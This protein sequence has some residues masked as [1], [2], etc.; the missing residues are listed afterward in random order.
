VSENGS[1]P[2]AGFRYGVVFLLILIVVV[3]L[4]VAPA[5]DWAFAAVF[6]LEGAALV[7]VV[8]TSRSRPDVRRARTALSAAAAA[9]WVL[10]VALGAIPAVLL[11]AA[12]GLITILI[13]LTLV[14]GLLRLVRAR[15]VTLQVVAGAL[16]IYLLLG[17]T[18]AW[19]IGLATHL[20]SAPYFASGT[21]GTQS[22]RVYFSFSVLTTTGFGDLTAGNA[23]GRALAVLEMLIG[24][25]YLVTVI[26]VLVGNFG[27]R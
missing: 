27:R 20:S 4:I 24:Q 18:F 23:P 5:N 1:A 16:A 19:V 9:A 15:G 17:L 10:G 7:V 6:A 25:L 3:V 22:T 21:D 2:A 11:Q 8:A 12:G 13:P 26:G 14:G